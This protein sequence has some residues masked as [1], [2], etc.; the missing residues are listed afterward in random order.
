[1]AHKIPEKFQF[2]LRSFTFHAFYGQIPTFIKRSMYFYKN[3]RR[4]TIDKAPDA[5]NNQFPKVSDFDVG[6]SSFFLP[7]SDEP[8]LA[9]NVISEK[10]EMESKAHER[11]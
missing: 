1:M 3:G 2:D 6:K 10:Y 11:R 4:L 7:S 8:S 9:S 5:L